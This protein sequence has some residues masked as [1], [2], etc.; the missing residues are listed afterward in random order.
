MTADRYS[1][2]PPE[3]VSPPAEKSSAEPTPAGKV[4]LVGAGPGDPGLITLRG[5][6][7]LA[8]ADVVLYDYLINPRLLEHC[9][10]DAIIICLGQH[11]RSRIWPQSEINDHLIHH[12]R[13]GKRVV[14]L[15][16][17][18]PAVFARGADEATALAEH[19]IA[20]E[21]VP[22]V[23]AALAAS[24]YAGIPIT[25]RGLASAVALVTGREDDDKQQSA[26]DFAALASF[27]GTLV[28]YMGVT[29]VARWTS[30]LIAAG[31]PASTPVAVV[32]R[33][34][35]PDQMVLRSTL[36]ELAAAVAAAKLRPPVIFIVGEVV[37]LAPTLSWFDRRPLFGK[38]V[39]V[40]RPLAQADALRA[41]LEE[42]GAE[43]LAQP[44]IAIE[45]PD[46]WEA[47][48]KALTSLDLY[49]WI[50]FSSVNGV[51]AFLGR[52]PE[53]GLDVRA[54]GN[55]RLAA[56][57]PGTA[58]ELARFHLR[59]D[60]VPDVHEAEALAQALIARIA[61]RPIKN[62]VLLVRASRGREV[63]AEQLLAAQA[64]VEQVV[65]YRSVD[66]H[67]PDPAIAAQLREGRID[68]VT[69]TS[70]AIARSAARLFGEDLRQAKLA[71]ISPITSATLRELGFEPAAEAETYTMQ[72]VVDAILSYEQAARDAR[73]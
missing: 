42:L 38:R 2:S 13:A 11:G 67:T 29:T 10:S 64:H 31:K 12:A 15:K 25:H 4:Y 55:V 62:R 3:T 66:L 59:A 49:D 47:V 24:S 51:R 44:A 20:F 37:D 43:V 32:R 33:C 21:I 54:F 57:G 56:I 8:Q 70:S 41:P 22:G 30:E 36:G 19:G 1:T 69:I 16:S 5:A 23:T 40:T 48:D 28:F 27:P 17:G 18:D 45:P 65:V 52:L 6:A 9:R 39:L 71:S 46:S 14:R 50:A 53:L 35:F 68:W 63:L 60:V 26:L 73:S 34:S 61:E 72:G 58:D 7:C